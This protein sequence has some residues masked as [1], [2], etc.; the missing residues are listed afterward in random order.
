[1]E[2]APLAL[3]PASPLRKAITLANSPRSSDAPGMNRILAALTLTLLA[4]TI[5]KAFLEAALKHAARGANR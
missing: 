2:K 3:K 4:F 5:K 1:M